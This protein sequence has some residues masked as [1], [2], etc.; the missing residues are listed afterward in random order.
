MRSSV[1]VKSV[2]NAEVSES[3]SHPLSI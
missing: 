1:A 2:W 3:T